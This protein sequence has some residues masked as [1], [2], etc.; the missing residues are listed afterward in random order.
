MPYWNSWFLADIPQRAPSKTPPT[1][2]SK[3]Q[4]A[5]VSRSTPTAVAIPRNSREARK[6][7]RSVDKQKNEQIKNIKRIR[8][9]VLDKL[10]NADIE[11]DDKNK[12]AGIIKII[13][14]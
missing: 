10:I 14:S 6:E 4:R 1:G 12:L 7:P 13:E 9:D 2:R 5:G 8:T 11:P 3:P